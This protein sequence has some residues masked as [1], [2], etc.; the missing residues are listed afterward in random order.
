MRS[1]PRRPLR[2][3]AREGCDPPVRR[4]LRLSTGRRSD[5]ETTESAAI[6]QGVHRWG[7]STPGCVRR[8]ASCCAAKLRRGGRSDRSDASNRRRGK[9]W[10]KEEQFLRSQIIARRR[11]IALTLSATVAIFRL[12]FGMLQTLAACSLA[13]VMLY[14]AGR[15]GGW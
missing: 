3:A 11:A 15:S 13:G 14:L 10:A 1:F 2:I 5:G 6:A 7:H 4:R 9:K 12:W 8:S